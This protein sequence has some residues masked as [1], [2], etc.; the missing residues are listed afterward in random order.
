M[1][2]ELAHASNMENLREEVQRVCSGTLDQ[3]SPEPSRKSVHADILF[4]MR[5]FKN[6]V[7]W[8]EFWRVQKQSTKTEVNEVTEENFRSMN[9]GRNTG[10]KPAFGIK[11]VKH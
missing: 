11:I 4:A 10:L 9:T 2:Q 8:K 7:G 6:V 3:F 5:R 1:S